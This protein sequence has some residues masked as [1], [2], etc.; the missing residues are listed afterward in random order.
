M[1]IIRQTNCGDIGSAA[2]V[3]AASWPRWRDQRRDAGRH[4]ADQ[5]DEYEQISP[6]NANTFLT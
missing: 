4:S 2:D 3:A 1:K 5:H 6:D